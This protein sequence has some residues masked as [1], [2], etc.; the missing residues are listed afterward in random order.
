MKLLSKTTLA[1]LALGIVAAAPAARATDVVSL[2]G[3]KALTAESDAFDRKRAMTASGGF[4]RAWDLQPPT[5]PHNIDNDRITIRENTCLNC[6][7]P[8]TFKKEK[9]PRIGDSHFV[10]ADGK[11]LETMNQ[12]RHFCSQCHVPQADVKPLVENTFGGN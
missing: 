10:D 2:R 8:E 7:G 9:A 12:R 5:I 3:D 4:D 1:A 11:V 6:H